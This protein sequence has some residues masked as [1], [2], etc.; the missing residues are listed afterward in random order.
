MSNFNYN[1]AI[2]GGRLTGDPELKTTQSGL[3][4]VAFTVAVARP[5]R[6]N[7]DGTAA[8]QQSD[9]INC[10]A[11][12][13]KA[14]FLSR[15]FRKGNA[16]FVEGV[17]QTRT[18]EDKQNVKHYVTECIANDIRF[19]DAKSDSGVAGFGVAQSPQEMRPQPGQTNYNPYASTPPQTAGAPP[20]QH[21]QPTAPQF[22]QVDDDPALPF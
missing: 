19:V 12:K 2:L 14:E 16:V 4:V 21:A 20:Q 9:F 7:D 15:Y 1:K 3:A 10:V 13:E 8:E 17:L 11:W 18:Y 5:R 22:E 6:K